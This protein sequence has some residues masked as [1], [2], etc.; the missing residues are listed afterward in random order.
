MKKVAIILILLIVIVGVFAFLNRE[1][2]KDKKLSQENAIITI[3]ADGTEYEVSFTEIQELE[4]VEFPAALRSSGKP[5]VDTSYTGVELKDI[6]EKKGIETTGKTQVIT[7][8]IDGY[9]VALSMEEVL[10]NDNVYVVYKRDGKDLGTKE[11]GG[12]GPYQIV[13]RQDE[14]GQRWN[15]FLMEIEIK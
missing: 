14:F 8:A 5:P 12:S 15:K 4:E 11:E 13:I 6:L 9:S 2:L 7:K 10:A 3:V 1:G